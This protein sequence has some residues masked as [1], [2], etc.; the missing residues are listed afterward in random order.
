MIS[1]VLFLL[2][3]IVSTFTAYSYTLD[4]YDLDDLT[5]NGE[6]ANHFSPPSNHSLL[7]SSLFSC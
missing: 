6:Y 7:Q 3:Y 2:S 5:L 1:A 4:D